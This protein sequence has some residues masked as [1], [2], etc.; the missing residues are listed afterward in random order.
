MLNGPLS[1]KFALGL[2]LAVM[3]GARPAFG[4]E[5]SS[6]RPDFNQVQTPAYEAQANYVSQT[7]LFPPFE[8]LRK[9]VERKLSASLRHRG[10]AHLT[11]VTPPEWKILTGAL[12]PSE[13]H[14]LARERKLQSR[15]FDAHCVGRAGSR[16]KEKS[17]STY[18]V[19]VRAPG[20]LEFREEL[21]R[22]YRAKGGRG[23]F[24]PRRYHPHVTLGFTHRDLHEQDGAV[25][26]DSSCL[27]SWEKN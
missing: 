18:F 22:L 10:E 19:V 8:K 1:V 9:E 20:A 26:D 14:N 17:L 5:W 7:L 3:C 13:I 23:P 27:F 11:V 16:E 25:K 4:S 15:P 21:D 6:L 24:D 2:I 12:T